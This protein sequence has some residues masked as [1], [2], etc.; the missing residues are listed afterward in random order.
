M[1]SVVRQHVPVFQNKSDFV[2][3]NWSHYY[4][5]VYGSSVL[6]H[7]TPDDF[8]LDPLESWL[9]YHDGLSASGLGFLA[10]IA[11][12][13]NRPDG[14]KCKSIRKHG[15]LLSGHISWGVPHALTIAHVEKPTVRSHQLIEITHC[16]KSCAN[17]K[18]CASEWHAAYMYHMPGSG[19]FYQTG[20]TKIFKTHADSATF[21]GFKCEK[22]PNC[23]DDSG[24][25]RAKAPGRDDMYTRAMDRVWDC[26]RN[27]GIDTAVFTNHR[28]MH[29]GDL[30]Q[31]IV[32]VHGIGTKCTFSNDKLFKGWRGWEGTYACTGVC[33]KPVNLGGEFTNASLPIGAPKSGKY[34][35]KTKYRRKYGRNRPGNI[36]LFDFN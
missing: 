24:V 14:K 35:M 36:D 11:L 8:P 15:A 13:V 21:C 17:G 31:E 33:T 28:D 32:D 34:S 19:V 22:P 18:F 2:A 1:L 9:W 30:Q 7:M 25:P 6:S 23:F 5:K 3:S 20:I 26:L 29:C 27:R 16:Q 12:N 10:D 4:S